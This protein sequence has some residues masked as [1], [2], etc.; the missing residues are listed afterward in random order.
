MPTVNSRWIIM[1]QQPSPGKTTIWKVVSKEG[2]FHL[3]TI[4]WF[5]NWRKYSFFP[6][7]QTIFETDCLT[8]ISNFMQQLMLERRASSLIKPV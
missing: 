7:P 3:G 8:D 1:V 6:E 2:N 5:T 4:K